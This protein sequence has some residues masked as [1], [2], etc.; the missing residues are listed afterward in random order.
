MLRKIPIFSNLKDDELSRLKDIAIIKKYKKGEFLF[1]EGDDPRWLIYLLSG[2]V[3][4]YK[5]SPKGKEI[6]LHQLSPMNFVAEL[7]NFE[8]IKYPANAVFSVSGEVL[9]IDY[10]K[11]RDEF[12]INP[13][14]S[15]EII[16]SLSEKLK[17]TSDILHQELVLNSEARVARFIVE[18]E[19]LF[20]ELKY[21]KISSILNITPET[22][23]RILNKFKT[24]NLIKFDNSNNLIFKDDEALIDIYDC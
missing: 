12:L 19:D 7:A 3:K 16:K 2:S 9:K 5:N 15:I 10:S 21:I 6:F 1:M 14:I 20:N 24:S 13:K 23:S 11:F 18:H 22:F 4:L 8:N 17:I